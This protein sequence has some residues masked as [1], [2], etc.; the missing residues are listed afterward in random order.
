MTSSSSVDVFN[1]VPRFVV[2]DVILKK[3]N[4]SFKEKKRIIVVTFP[5]GRIMNLPDIKENLK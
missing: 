3:K 2:V 5:C 4:S 1:R